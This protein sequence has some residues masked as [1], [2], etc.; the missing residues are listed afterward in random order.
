MLNDNVLMPVDKQTR[1]L[2]LEIYQ[3]IK[4]L[5][6]IS[7]HGHTDPKWFDEN[8]A[9]ENPVELLIKPDHYIFRMFY[10]QG[11]RLEDFG[12]TRKDDKP[13]ETDT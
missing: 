5:P 4:N 8:Q 7:P 9:F 6:I 12:I 10:S 2:A 11:L 1:D 3:H 13:V